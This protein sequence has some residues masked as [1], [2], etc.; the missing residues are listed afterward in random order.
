MRPARI[1][2]II[3]FTA[4]VA[5][6]G[7]STHT[8]TRPAAAAPTPSQPPATNPTPPPTTPPSTTPPPTRPTACRTA[9]LHLR[10]VMEDNGMGHHWITYAFR[11]RSAVACTLSG[12][13]AVQL[14]DAHGGVLPIVRHDGPGSTGPVVL[15]RPGGSAF[16]SIGQLIA[17]DYDGQP[18]PAATTLAVTPPHQRDAL[19]TTTGLAPCGGRLSLSAIRPTV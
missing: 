18:C 5:V 4:A 11:N 13:P 9:Q 3:V 17:P 10:A 16:F 8:T 1:I 19:T 12:V 6:T 2:A 14:L 7:C 15:L